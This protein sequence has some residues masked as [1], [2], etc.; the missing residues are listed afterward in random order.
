MVVFYKYGGAFWTLDYTFIRRNKLIF[1]KD[2]RTIGIYI[3]NKNPNNAGDK[4][5]N[6]IDKNKI[7]YIIVILTASLIIIGLVVFILYKF[8]LSKKKKKPFVLDEDFEY[9]P[10]IKP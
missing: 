2:K 4:P 5:K 9:N 10:I 3:N 8:V 1:D 7:I 6:P